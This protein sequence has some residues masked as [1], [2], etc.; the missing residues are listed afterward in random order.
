MYAPFMCF[1][2]LPCLLHLLTVLGQMPLRQ[3]CQAQSCTTENWNEWFY[4][5]REPWSSIGVALFFSF[6]ASD[7]SIAGAGP[8]RGDGAMA[9]AGGTAPAAGTTPEGETMG[10]GKSLFESGS[11]TSDGPRYSWRLAV[12]T[13]QL[14]AK[15]LQ[16]A[17]VLHLTTSTATIATWLWKDQLMSPFN[18]PWTIGLLLVFLDVFKCNGF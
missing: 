2:Q 11:R 9:N 7:G 15:Q 16:L 17:L 8:I 14:K 3:N 18:T 13:K 4:H 6:I 5:E 10:A 1:H 12:P